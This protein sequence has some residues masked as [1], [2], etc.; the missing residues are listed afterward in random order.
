MFTAAGS[1]FVEKYVG[2]G[3]QRIRAL[4]AAARKHER[5]I[6]FIDVFSSSVLADT[7]LQPLFGAGR[8]EHL[9]Q[10]SAFDSES[11]GGPDEFTRSMGGFT[12][13]ID[14]LED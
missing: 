11:F 13:L 4:F 10:L 2:V 6:I 1:D 7:F 5:A 12:H 9:E 14:V 8:P 3:A